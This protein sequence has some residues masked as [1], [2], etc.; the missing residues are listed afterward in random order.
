MRSSN[1]FGDARLRVL[2]VLALA[3]GPLA[4]PSE[5]P[6]RAD[7][8]EAPAT[9]DALLEGFRGMSGLEARFEEEKHVALLATPLTSRGRLYF[10]PPSALL[11]R[12]EW[13]QV[14][15]ILIT[16]TGVRLRQSGHEE[17]IDLRARPEVRPLVESMLWIFR[18]DRAALETAFRVTYRRLEGED[19]GRFRLT[20]APRGAPLDR[21]IAELVIEGRGFAVER[22]EVRETSGDRTVTRIVDANPR[23]I[24]T[25]DERR[26]LFGADGR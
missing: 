20:L 7:A 13:P 21:L 2:A 17:V 15:D 25:A 10:A 18:G 4:A 23:R 19:A 8:I 1:A 24:F 16:P 5:A 12:V 3:L 9:L 22:V 11:R 14:A 6:A 26:A